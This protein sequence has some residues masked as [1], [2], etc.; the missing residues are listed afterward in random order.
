MWKRTNTRR[1]RERREGKVVLFFSKKIIYGV[2]HLL[3]LDT[4]LHL[5]A[6]SPF[7]SNGVFRFFVNKIM[8]Y[9]LYHDRSLSDPP[10]SDFNCFI[11]FLD[12]KYQFFIF[13]ESLV[14]E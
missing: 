13:V 8:L 11:E 4:P 5:V 10:S 1:E 9:S 3:R 12:V 7:F 14:H 2:R 6:Q